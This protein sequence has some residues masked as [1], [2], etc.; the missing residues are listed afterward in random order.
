M[1]NFVGKHTQRERELV[2]QSQIYAAPAAVRDEK[3][4]KEANVGAFFLNWSTR[5][6]KIERDGECASLFLM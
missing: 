6:E 3:E 1:S 5:T 2:E 4:R